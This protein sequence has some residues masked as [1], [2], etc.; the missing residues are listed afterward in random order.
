MGTLSAAAGDAT[1]QPAGTDRESDSMA[2]A[3]ARPTVETT[4]TTVS[5][6]PTDA[7]TTLA[8]PEK[9]VDSTTY[10][11]TRSSVQEKFGIKFPTNSGSGETQAPAGII[12]SLNPANIVTHLYQN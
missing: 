7:P 12:I 5:P 11:M 6:F 3:T 1:L 2:E 8:P 4:T 10:E 9:T